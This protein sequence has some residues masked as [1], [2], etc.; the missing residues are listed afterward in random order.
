MLSALMFAV[1]IH[2]TNCS[3]FSNWCVLTVRN[4]TVYGKV[5]VQLHSLLISALDGVSNHFYIP[6]VLPHTMSSSHRLNNGL[7][8]LQSWEKPFVLLGIKPWFHY[9][10]VHGLFTIVKC[11]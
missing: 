7:C 4:K 2:D 10:I 3:Q 6:S 11:A 1:T 8:G 5:D 9:F